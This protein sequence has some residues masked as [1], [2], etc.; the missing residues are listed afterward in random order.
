[1]EVIY[2]LEFGR[3]RGLNSLSDPEPPCSE[4]QDDKDN[5]L[6]WDRVGVEGCDVRTLRRDGLDGGLIVLSS[7]GVVL[8]VTKLAKSVAGSEVAV[9]S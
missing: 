9:E 2:L 7:A 4:Q 3:G 5:F 6:L 1:M 8:K